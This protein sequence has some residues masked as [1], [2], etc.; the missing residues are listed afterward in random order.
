[1]VLFEEIQQAVEVF[2]ANILHT[3]VFHKE[4]KL[5][6]PPFVM[7]QSWDGGRLVVPLC[8]QV[9]AEEVVSQDTRLWQAVASA[10]DFEVYPAISV[11][12]LEVVRE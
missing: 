4:A 8:F 12:S 2:Q 7:P 6:W 5:F 3:K 11:P 1:M 10:A 9:F